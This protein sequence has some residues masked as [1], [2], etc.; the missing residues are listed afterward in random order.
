MQ[1]SNVNYRILLLFFALGL[2]IYSYA[3]N[4]KIYAW[5]DKNGV[6]VFSDTPRSGAHEIK[7]NSQDL[8]LSDTD[9]HTPDSLQPT[10]LNRFQIMISALRLNNSI[11]ARCYGALFGCSHLLLKCF[12]N[13]CCLRAVDTC[14]STVFNKA[15]MWFSSL[16]CSGIVQPVTKGL[17]A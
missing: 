16:S 9:K 7:L 4:D 3:G 6:L 2:S 1:G 5:K 12:E 14:C 10:R 13:G 11:Y 15:L 17:T 8:T